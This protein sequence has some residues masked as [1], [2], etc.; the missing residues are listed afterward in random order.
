MEE[1]N[2]QGTSLEQILDN[3]KLK[4]WEPSKIGVWET[5]LQGQKVPMYKA[6][7][8]PTIPQIDKE[9]LIEE[10]RRVAPKRKLVKPVNLDKPGYVLEVGLVDLHFGAD[11]DNY[12]AEQEAFAAIEHFINTVDPNYVNQIIFPVGND[13]LN[14]DSTKNETTKGTPQD[15]KERWENTFRKASR[16]LVDSISWLEGIAP[17]TVPVVRGNH[18]SHST[19]GIGTLLD[20]RFEKDEYVTVLAGDEERKYI[21]FG[22]NLVGFTHGDERVVKS[23]KL[24]SI[25]ATE[26]PELWAASKWR[27]WHLGHLH[28][29]EV[30]DINGAIIRR[31]PTLC[32]NGKWAVDRGFT[33]TRAAQAFVWDYEAGLQQSIYFRTT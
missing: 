13:L 8:V 11:I 18:D 14:T 4:G 3:P 1:I 21:P 31:I 26:V 22:K 16:F 7:L 17:V 23:N 20:I 29:E 25:M 32:G 6:T 33:S 5:T 19:F 24:P 27:E 28:Q 9:V 12:D 10:L 30:Q 2:I 15:V